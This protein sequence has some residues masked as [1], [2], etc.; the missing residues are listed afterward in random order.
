MSTTRPVRPLRL[1]V[2][3]ALGALVMVA[4]C[5]DAGPG[6]TSGAPTGLAALPATA[7]AGPAGQ[8]PGTGAQ[9]VASGGGAVSVVPPRWQPRLGVTWQWQLTGR[10]DT[11]VD[12]AV[13]DVDLFT[14]SATQVASL[15]AQGRRVVCY[16][17]AG[18]WE[19]YRPDSAAF[20]AGVR[21]RPLAGFEDERW[22]DVRQTRVL[23]PIMAA[24]LDLCRRKGFDAAEP[25]NVDGYANR[26]GFP[27]RSA[28]Q[29]RYNR[30][31]AGLAHARGLAVALKNDLDQ[32]A[33][34]E[35][36]FDFAVNEQCAEFDECDTL[37]PF[38]RAGKPVLHVEYDVPR[39][40]FCPT[41]KRLRL[42]SLVKRVSLDAYRLACAA[43]S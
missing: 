21:G 3:A 24:R 13:Y 43:G 2:A 19:P 9:P 8:A 15:K 7:S 27:V 41:S 12:A 31:L 38:L 10:L 6:R 16:F 34:L 23:L 1:L 5:A 39:A 37:T 18:S 26:T 17:S 40:D 14:T 42:S 29:L 33:V 32:V 30:A 20:P 11:R 22:L 35:P 25:D 28:E 36:D 4:G